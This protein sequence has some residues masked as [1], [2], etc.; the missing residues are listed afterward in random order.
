[1]NIMNT[2]LPGTDVDTPTTSSVVQKRS[3]P[4]S[5]SVFLED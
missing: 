3:R 5:Q 4:S 1:M 2:T